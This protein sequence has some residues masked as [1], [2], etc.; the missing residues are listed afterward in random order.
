MNGQ[1]S[2]GHLASRCGDR[3]QRD[4]GLRESLEDLGAVGEL[5]PLLRAKHC[6]EPTRSASSRTWAVFGS[7]ERRAMC[8]RQR[9]TWTSTELLDC[10]SHEKRA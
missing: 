7:V 10:R 5:P 3:D 6:L 8:P 9:R 1:T 2:R 4:V